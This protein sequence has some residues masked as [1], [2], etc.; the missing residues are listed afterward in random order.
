[1]DGMILWPDSE[2]WAVFSQSTPAADSARLDQPE[3]SCHLPTRAER[4]ALDRGFLGV[5]EHERPERLR[6][7]PTVANDVQA[8]FDAR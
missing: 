4:H 6:L 8:S 1:M 7:S 3:K 5:S 2:C